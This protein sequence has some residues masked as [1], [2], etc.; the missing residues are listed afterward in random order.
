[1]EINPKDLLSIQEVL[2]DVIV[3]ID[4]EDNDKL[5]PGFYRAQVKYGLDEL[6][7]DV[8]FVKV[9]EDY[10]M[11]VDLI[12]DMPS[13]CFNLHTIHLFTGTPDNV[14]YV[15]NVYWKK[16]GQTR[17]KE[18]G[19]TANQTG[20]NTGDPFCRVEVNPNSLYYFTIQNGII[21][22]SDSCSTYPFARLTFAGVPS[23]RMD[24]VKMVP[25]MVRKALVLWATE[26]C[27]GALK[28]RDNTYRVIQS[29]A[30][31]QLDEYGLGGAW[32]EAKTRL[33]MLDKKMLNDVIL[34]NARLNY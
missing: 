27:A 32:H 19:F 11:P 31:N 6:G 8:P 16:G 34:Y 29:D 17:G 21:R 30:A 13:G 18:T 5:T 28:H 1:M 14:G 25:R 4:D 7:F 12:L 24:D 2:A 10:P 3:N 9:T 23:M 15:E 33:K 20:F 22:L 26:K